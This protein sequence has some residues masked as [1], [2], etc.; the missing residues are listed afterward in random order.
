MVTVRDTG[1]RLQHL[2]SGELVEVRVIAANQLDEA[3]PSPVAT[4]VVR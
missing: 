1:T 4:V 3:A 2:A